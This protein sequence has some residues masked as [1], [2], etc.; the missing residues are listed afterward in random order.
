MPI[1]Q[2]E[3]LST[4]PTTMHAYRGCSPE[5]RQASLPPL[6]LAVSARVTRAFQEGRCGHSP[7]AEGGME[8]DGR[9][10]SYRGSPWRDQIPVL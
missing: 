6:S 10:S 5:V 4:F 9:S 7:I 3:E 1:L 8:C 2:H